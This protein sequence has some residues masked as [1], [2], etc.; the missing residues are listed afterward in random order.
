MKN[1]FCDRCANILRKLRTD[2]EYQKKCM[3]AIKLGTCPPPLPKFCDR[4]TK[5]MDHFSGDITD[6]LE[7]KAPS[8]TD[9][10]ITVKSWK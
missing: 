6:I 9:A 8:N 2:K 3:T 5:A 7:E 10:I 1:I 4:C